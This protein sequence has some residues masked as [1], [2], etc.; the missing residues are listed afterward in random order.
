[1]VDEQGWVTPDSIRDWIRSEAEAAIWWPFASPSIS[2]GPYAQLDIGAGTTNISIFRIVAKHNRFGWQKSSVS[3]FGATSPPVG[4]DAFDKAI[5]EWKG[6]ANPLQWR[7]RE[8]EVL[9]G[10]R[11]TQLVSIELQQIHDA[12]GRTIH[13]AFQQSLQLH[14]E[15]RVW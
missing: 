9:F 13:K 6:D 14:Q 10:N 8:D 15:Q 11:G 2:D 12:Y 7:G 3:F 4:L 1:Q 5:A